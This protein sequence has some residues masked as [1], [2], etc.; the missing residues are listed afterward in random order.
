MRDDKYI[1][2]YA[3]NW[4]SYHAG[5]RTSMFNYSLAA[6]SLLAAGFG[7]T[8]ATLPH[9]AAA[10]AFV[11][12]LV[13]SSFLLIDRRNGQL[14]HR[15]ERVLRALEHDA[16]PEIPQAS[17]ADASYPMPAGILIVNEKGVRTDGKEGNVFIQYAR[18]LHRVHLRLIEFVFF[19]AFLIGAVGATW[20]P[21]AF[22]TKDLT[23]LQSV[24]LLSEHV[25]RLDA[26]LQVLTDRVATARADVPPSAL[27]A[28]QPTPTSRSPSRDN[29]N[30]RH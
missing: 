26:S 17:K 9:V 29:L 21:G 1:R 3:W 18:G 20:K 11:G 6:A 4:F 16:F 27:P 24:Q 8:I 19:I 23:V 28:S 14:I 5:Q 15:G 13:T 7:A 12:V 10:I 30:D 25:V 22:Q 2:E